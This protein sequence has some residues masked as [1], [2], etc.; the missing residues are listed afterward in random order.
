MSAR[1]STCRLAFLLFLP[2][3]HTWQP[4]KLAPNTAFQTDNSV[5]VERKAPSTD[6]PVASANGSAGKSRA[7][8][9]FHGASVDGD[10]LLGVR[11]ESAQRVAIADVRRAEEHRFSGR[12]TTRLVV[13]VVG[14]AL[15][16]LLVIGLAAGAAG[17]A[18]Y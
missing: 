7:W 13:G 18:A 12:Q 9:V 17:A 8:V 4:V 16:G 6:S 2:A 14:I 15:L 3:C 11:S 1:V 10:S 5:R